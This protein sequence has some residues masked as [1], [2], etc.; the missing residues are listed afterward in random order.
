MASFVFVSLPAWGHIDFGGRGFLRTARGLIESGHTVRW[1]LA[2]G[3]DATAAGIQT[4]ISEAGVPVERLDVSLDLVTNPDVDRAASAVRAFAELL[5]VRKVDV[6]VIDRL[7]MLAGVAAHLAGVPWSVVG[8]NGAAWM[9]VAGH[10]RCRGTVPGPFTAYPM[11]ELCRNVGASDFPEHARDT[12]WAISPFLNLSFLFRS[13]FP[14]A[15]V[16]PTHFVGGSSG[17]GDDRGTILVT[18]GTTF[19]MND[20]IPSLLDMC[21]RGAAGDVDVELLTG[22]SAERT[23]QLARRAAGAPRLTIRSWLPYE[24]AFRGARL[25]IGHGG[26]GFTW[27][28]LAAAIPIM[29]IPSINGDQLFGAERIVALGAGRILDGDGL[30]P[31]TLERTLRDPSLYDRTRSHELARV[32]ASGGSVGAAVQLLEVLATTREP[33]NTCV[34]PRCCCNG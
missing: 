13:F 1:L 26:N 14:D 3:T 28:A 25:A 18:L 9:R 10:L 33:V 31:E 17:A 5:K 12:F 15:S 4:A 34:E 23:E 27:H 16:A 8:S 20:F 6:C 7:S 30:T 32:L 24:V 22:Y 19:G 2:G 11:A 21:A 29:A